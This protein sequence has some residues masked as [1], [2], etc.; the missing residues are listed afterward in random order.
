M[1]LCRWAKK[2]F[3]D[4]IKTDE[5]DSDTRKQVNQGWGNQSGEK[6]WDD[7]KAGEN[8]AQTDETEPQTPGE[9]KPEEAADKSKSYAEYLAEKAAQGDLSAKPV[10]G[11]NEGTKLDKKWAAAKELK[12]SE[13]E[14]AYIKGKED[15][16]KR[17]KQ[18]KEKNILEVDMRFVEAPRTGGPGPRGRGGRGGPRG[19]R[20]GRGNGPR[21]ERP[22]AAA[23]AAPT[24]A[25]DEKNFPSLGGK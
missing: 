11:P 10:R 18:R 22:A 5:L 6:T 25:V 21:S 19:G 15:K 4:S 8:I 16:A 13:E 20:G 3:W 2:K 23:A 14:D 24:V 7:E 12:R 9:E 1:S 17:E